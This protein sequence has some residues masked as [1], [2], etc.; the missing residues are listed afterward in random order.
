MSGVRRLQQALK[1]PGSYIKQWR[2]KRKTKANLDSIASALS[3]PGKDIDMIR[4]GRPDLDHR[5]KNHQTR[6]EGERKK[7]SDQ[8]PKKHGGTK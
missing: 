8:I 6:W 5:S 7:I 1:V 4:E 3:R 2:S